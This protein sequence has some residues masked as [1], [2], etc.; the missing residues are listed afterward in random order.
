MTLILCLVCTVSRML[1]L[2]NDDLLTSSDVNGA[3]PSNIG[4]LANWR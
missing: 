1:S 2:T 3:I 4:G